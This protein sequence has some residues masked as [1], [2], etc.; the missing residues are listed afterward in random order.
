MLVL[1]AT[2]W[3]IDLAIGSFQYHDVSPGVVAFP[4]WIPQAAMAFG[5]IVM[6]LCLL[7]SLIGTWRG[8]TSLSPNNGEQ[9]E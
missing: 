3:I 9:G 5:L 7:E 8:I 6:C 2:W 1:F 4:L